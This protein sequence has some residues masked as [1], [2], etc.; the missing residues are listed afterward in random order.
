MIIG[1]SG[2]RDDGSSAGAGKDEVAKI[3][4]R[5]HGFVVV[6][7]ADE[8]KRTAMLW[9]DFTPEQLWGSKKEEPDLRYPREHGPLVGPRQT[10]ACCGFERVWKAPEPQCYLN[11]R[12]VFRVIGT[13]VGRT[14]FFDTWV[15]I[16]LKVVKELLVDVTG[17]R[18]HDYDKYR[19][20][21]YRP[22]IGLFDRAEGEG[23]HGD[24]IDGV[25]IPDVRW[26]AG[27]EG[28]AIKATG[29]QLWLVERPGT[30]QTG[31]AAAKHASETQPVPENA[32][33]LILRNRTTLEDLA[34]QV[35]L[36][37]RMF[38]NDAGTT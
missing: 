38:A 23:A 9:Y 35:A 3:L 2:L 11:P 31:T 4:A 14:I 33:D 34:G 15:N 28:K 16:T 5:E 7:F 19:R 1:L 17:G 12:F 22:E 32:F 24:R 26:P 37:A 30:A 27:N 18:G 10:C 29:G 6:S 8:I 25:V 21:N 36:A 13:E 20:H